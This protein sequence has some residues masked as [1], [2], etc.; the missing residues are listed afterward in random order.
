MA[1]CAVNGGCP[2][3]YAAV[4]ISL[5]SIFLL[6]GKAVAPHLIHK[7]ALP[8]GSSFWLVTI[9]IIASFN[10]IVSI[11]MS[12]G[13]LRF[14]RG[15]WWSSC[16]I[17]A[18]WVEGPLGF[19]LLLSSRIVQAFQ[20]Y[21]IFVRRRLPPIRSFIFLPLVLLPWIIGAAFLHTKKP[22]NNRCHMRTQW[23]IPVICLHA[24]YV[25]AMVGFTAAI[26]HIEFRFHELKDLWRGILVSTC[27]I[28][29]WVIAYILNETH[30]DIPLVQIVTRFLILVMTSVLVL[31]FFS[32]S[33]S[34]PLLSLMSLRKDEHQEYSMMMGRALGIPDSGLLVRTESLQSVDS[35]EPFDKLLSNR[36]FRQSFME[37]AD[38]CLA[39]ESVHFYEEVQQLDR[40]PDS[41]HVRRI[42]MARHIIDRYIAPGATM[43]VNISHRCRQE[44]LSTLDLAH[45]NLFK[46]A[47]IELI[48]LM[49]MNLANDYWSSTFYMKLKDE[50]AMKTVD[51]ELET[52]G[53]N[54]SQRLSSVHCTD[55][56]FHQEHSPRKLG[57]S[58]NRDTELQLREK[59]P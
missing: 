11:V 32:I 7:I 35:N 3:D 28:G 38:S 29:I 6:I 34:Q 48:H 1:T 31:V 40:I 9:Q 21:Y 12:L 44:I 54:F 43:E 49:K 5:L 24:L 2:S 25:A 58:T 13:F 47:L 53:W 23:I 37:F 17:W 26:R 59:F 4:S 57:S 8:K 55:D 22:L 15:H 39:G 27:S 41:D 14:K 10:L 52:G 42:Y 16:Y 46:N 20:L 56:P 19:G 45:A 18:V 50:A 33:I 51:H 30:E 36:R